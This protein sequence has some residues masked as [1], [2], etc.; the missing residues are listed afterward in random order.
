M[1][2]MANEMAARMREDGVNLEGGA[3]EP[4][5]GGTTPP[6]AAPSAETLN[7]ET[8]QGGQEP[9]PVP[10]SRFREVNE[11]Y[12][13][14]RGYETLM[15][16]GYDPDSLGRLAQFE[17]AWVQDPSS[18]VAQMVDNLDLPDESKNQIRELLEAEADEASAGAGT[19]T[20]PA[21]DGGEEPPAWAKPLIEDYQGRTAASQAQAEDAQRQQALDEV[22][23]IWNEM[24][25]A[26]GI[27]TTEGVKLA[28]IASHASSGRYQD[29]RSLAEGAR[30]EYISDREAAM[31]SA[32]VPSSG[33][34]GPRSV[35]RS[36]AAASPPQKFRDL[37]EA[38]KAAMGAIE[39]GELPPINLGG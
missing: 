10:Y 11:A 15:Q 18:T 9:G 31:G 8:Q 39:R 27:K 5:T 22:L 26:A 33:G 32:I 25:T 2:G 34:I 13:N 29:A 28:L 38:T 12:Q 19:P 21:A 7:A 14:L 36:A 30:A 23:G 24:D 1:S 37:R 16:Y 6:P 35:P 20:T 4:G 3:A 17:A